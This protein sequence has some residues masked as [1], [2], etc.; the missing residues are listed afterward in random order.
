VSSNS[1]GLPDWANATRKRR[2]HIERVAEVV[3]DWAT[4]IGVSEHERRRWLRAVYLHDA[5]KDA[6]DEDLEKLVPAEPY[7]TALKH[8]PAAAVL[9]ERF[10]E[11]DEGV[12]DAV[13]YHSVG[14]AGWDWS[15]KILYMADYLEPGRKFRRKWRAGLR[16]FAADEPESALFEVARARMEWLVDSGW[17]ISRET[18]DFW[19]SIVKGE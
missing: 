10:G 12:L 8:G 9:A 11:T 19:N 5:I 16:G 3:R 7:I 15:G 13:R 2:S 17:P 6:S 1:E 4:T 18:L 14:F